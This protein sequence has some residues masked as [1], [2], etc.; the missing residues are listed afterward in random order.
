MVQSPTGFWVLGTVLGIF[1]GPVQ[2]AS[3]S[4]LASAAPEQ[5]RTQ[6]FGLFAF[7]GKATAFLG[8]VL[9]AWITGL[10]DSQRAGMSVI[11]FFLVAGLVLM[12][13]LPGASSLRR[14]LE[15]GG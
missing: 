1:V 7:S 11:L 10:F 9:V 12:L 5:L 15:A 8:P 14:E 3:R 4:Y 13:T 6:L 2:A